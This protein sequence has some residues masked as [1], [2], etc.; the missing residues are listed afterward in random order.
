TKSK[1]VV[2]AGAAVGGAV[3]AA[4]EAAGTVGTAAADAAG[5]TSSALFSAEGSLGLQAGKSPKA[6]M[7]TRVV[8]GNVIFSVLVFIL[9]CSWIEGE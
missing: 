9:D 4:A 6:R 3:G 5:A 2:G 7:L 8:I 1:G